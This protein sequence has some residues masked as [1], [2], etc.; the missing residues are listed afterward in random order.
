MCTQGS[1]A[2]IIS[3]FAACL[4]QPEV[5]ANLWDFLFSHGSHMLFAVVLGLLEAVEEDLLSKPDVPGSLLSVTFFYPDLDSACHGME[6]QSALS[7]SIL[8]HA[9]TCSFEFQCRHL[10]VHVRGGRIEALATTPFLRTG[11]RH[12]ACSH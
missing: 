9:C 11:V 12:V 8:C 7:S 5:T 1:T 6:C 2:S 3:S 10:K 4:L